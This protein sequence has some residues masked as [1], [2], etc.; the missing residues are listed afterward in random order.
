MIFFSAEAES[1]EYLTENTS[2]LSTIILK[3]QETHAYRR[4]ELKGN[5]STFEYIS[6]YPVLQGNNGIKL[7][8]LDVKLLYSA[9]E[10]VENWLM[11]YSNV[12]NHARTLRDKAVCNLLT[13]IDTSTEERKC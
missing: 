6:K 8:T 9:T 1:I 2:D 7:T 13:K 5:I 10:P 4:N 3:W 12:L 11:I